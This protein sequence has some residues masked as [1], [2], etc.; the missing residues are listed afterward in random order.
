MPMGAPALYGVV[1]DVTNRKRMEQDVEA[2]RKQLKRLAQTATFGTLS[3]AL[4]HELNQPL[5]AIMSNA[6]AAERMLQQD[7]INVTELGNTLRDIIEDDARAGAVIHAPACA[8]Q[9]R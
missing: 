9:E 5:A 7:R 3:G 2:M 6:Q 1:I 4:A 8:V